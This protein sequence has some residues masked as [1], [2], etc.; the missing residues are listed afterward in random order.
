MVDATTGYEALSFMDGF[1]GYNQIRM[2]P[3]DEK[4]TLFHTQKVFIVIVMLLGLKNV[5]ATYQWAVQRIFEYLLH[6]K[7]EC[8]V[9][10]LVVKTKKTRRSS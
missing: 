3:K 10:D 1:S 2:N 7:F 6:E 8:H 5:G 4:L 9:D